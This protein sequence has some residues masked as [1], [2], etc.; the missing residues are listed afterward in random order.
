MRRRHHDLVRHEGGGRAAGA[1]G[2]VWDSVVGRHGAS[3]AP[4]VG[5][6]ERH[7]LG[8]LLW[9][10]LRS[11]QHLTLIVHWK[12]LASAPSPRWG[13]A[14]CSLLEHLPIHMHD[15]SSPIN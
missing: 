3:V 4:V 11:G 15:D 12:H 5:D 6:A 1:G 8:G 2:L 10:L 9:V 14:L 13:K 7:V